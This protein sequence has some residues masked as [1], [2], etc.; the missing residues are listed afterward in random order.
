MELENATFKS[1]IDVIDIGRVSVWI[2]AK[3][4]V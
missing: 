2:I 1:G 3:I 4:N